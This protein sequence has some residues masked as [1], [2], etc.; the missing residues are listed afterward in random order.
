MLRLSRML[1]ETAPPGATAATVAA[2]FAALL[3]SAAPRPPTRMPMPPRSARPSIRP[4]TEGPAPTGHISMPAALPGAPS[5]GWHGRVWLLAGPIIVSNL[6]TPLLGAVD[7]AVVGRLPDAAYIGGV[8]LGAVIFNFLYWGFGFLRMGTTG[9]TAQAFGAGDA[10]ELRAALLRPALL[11]LV[12]GLLLLVLQA[13]LG[14][15]AFALLEASEEVEG[16]AGTYYGIR[17]WS[18]PAA[19]LNYAVLGWLLGTQR[20]RATL[21]LQVFLNGTNIVLDI[22]FVIGL[23]WGIAGVAWAS[24]IAE[25]AAAGLGLAIIGRA[26]R[27]AGGRWDPARMFRRDRLV[28]LLRVNLDIFLRTLSLIVAFSYFTAQ[29]A[30]M[31]DVPLAANAILMHLQAFVAYG[32]DGFAHAAE[33]LAGG[34][35]GA[36][37]RAAFRQAVRTSTVWALGTALGFAAV[38]ALLGAPVV[39]LFTVIEEV[40]AAAIVYLPWLVLSPLISVWS[41]QLDGIFIGAT[42]TGAMRNA[43]VLSLLAFLAAVWLLVPIWGNHGLW[44]AFALFMATRAVTLGAAYPRLERSIA[45]RG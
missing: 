31:G 41:F 24:V 29:G 12:L 43:M 15:I 37:S 44:L 21:M 38:Y 30:K 9:F 23:G 1:S 35:V 11:A 13:P 22:A 27:G 42:R 34:A 5:G 45:A 3:S 33:I 25:V 28:A 18:A 39:R 10:D 19:L 16:F 32:L 6:S 26:L 2:G 36:R 7:T 40:R 20:A 14:W 17:I 4:T 8:A